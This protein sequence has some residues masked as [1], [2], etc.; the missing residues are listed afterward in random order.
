MGP[1]MNL[2]LLKRTESGCAK[3]V[4]Y[5]VKLLFTQHFQRVNDYPHIFLFYFDFSEFNL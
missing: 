2:E 1:F 3:L 5:V 4:S